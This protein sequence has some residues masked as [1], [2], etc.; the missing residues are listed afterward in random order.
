MNAY[1]L[2]KMFLLPRPEN[3]GLRQVKK[4]SLSK[5]DLPIPGRDREGEL[6]VSWRHGKTKDTYWSGKFIYRQKII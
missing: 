4:T 6:Y 5:E 2:E 3:G 1:S